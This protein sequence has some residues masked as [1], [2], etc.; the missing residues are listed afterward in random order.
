MEPNSPQHCVQHVLKNAYLVTKM[1][2][3]SNVMLCHTQDLLIKRHQNFHF[4]FFLR[5][6]S[7][8]SW[9]PSDDSGAGLWSA[10]CVTRVFYR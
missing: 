10:L 6:P 7:L 4:A 3:T 1:Y 2:Y 5:L 9:L 8:R